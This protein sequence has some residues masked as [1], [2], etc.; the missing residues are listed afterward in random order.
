V[1]HPCG[2]DC[3]YSRS[4]KKIASIL[5]RTRVSVGYAQERERESVNG[6]REQYVD[7]A[8]HIDCKL[9]NPYILVQHNV[10]RRFVVLR[11]VFIL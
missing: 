4:K 1:L 5:D 3:F 7:H 2:V 9:G 10:T 8:C 6:V 11:K